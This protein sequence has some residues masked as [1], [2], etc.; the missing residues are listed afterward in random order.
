MKKILF[1]IAFIAGLSIFF[2]FDKITE[3]YINQAIKTNNIDLTYKKI[4]S[5]FFETKIEDVNFTGIIF[6]SIELSYNPLFYPFN[7]KI[8]ITVKAREV[9]GKINI[10]GKN[11]SFKTNLELSLLKKFNKTLNAKGLLSIS[12][13]VNISKFTGKFKINSK[14]ILY[15]DKQ[16]GNMSFKNV[17]GIAF[18]QHMTLKI[19][20]LSSQDIP[21]NIKGNIKINRKDFLKSRLN[22]KG[23]LTFA[24]TKNN[25]KI[26]G[27][28]TSP[29]VY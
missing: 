29:R 16:W 7:K 13:N 3:Y 5:S 19:K 8:Y 22:L 28:L 20:Q 14:N 9:N 24:G 17:E 10:T 6:N 27:T 25:F 23:T 12:G 18:L 15:K 1:L 2:P 26:K 11:L 4:S 21:L